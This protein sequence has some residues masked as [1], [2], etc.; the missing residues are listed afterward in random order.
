MRENKN[1][2]EF[3]NIWWYLI[4]GGGDGVLVSDCDNHHKEKY[5]LEGWNHQ[6]ETSLE[7]KTHL[8]G[9]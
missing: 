1:V 5:T 7:M 6:V 9:I 4:D 2:K 8:E 3:F